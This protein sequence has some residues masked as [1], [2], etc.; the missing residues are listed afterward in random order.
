[1]SKFNSKQL[2][3]NAKSLLVFSLIN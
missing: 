2:D 1:M 3:F